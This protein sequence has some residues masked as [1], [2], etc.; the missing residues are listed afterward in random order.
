[1]KEIDVLEQRMAT[2]IELAGERLDR[3][4]KI[5]EVSWLAMIAEGKGYM[6]V[7]DAMKEPL[8]TLRQRYKDLGQDVPVFLAPMFET[9]EKMKL[10]PK[11][12]ENLDAS[13][14]IL[15][16]LTN[17]A[18]LTQG[19]FNALT[20]SATSF[21]KTILGAKGNL[22]DFMDTAELTQSQKDQL[23]PTVY[24]VRRVS[25]SL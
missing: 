18:Y 11:I 21:A 7:L 19:A 12:F 8:E 5:T 14:T 24:S 2:G 17:S 22:N 20:S 6:E 9:L 13:S 25:R 10:F 1:M 23:M 15:E 3:A 16:S 4:A